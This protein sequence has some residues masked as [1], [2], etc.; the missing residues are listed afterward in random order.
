M[1]VLNPSCSLY[2]YM[3]TNFIPVLTAPFTAAFTARLQKW[4]TAM[5]D[6]KAYDPG[7]SLRSYK[8]I[9]ETESDAHAYRENK[10]IY[11]SYFYNAN[12]FS[13]VSKGIMNRAS[14]MSVYGVVFSFRSLRFFHQNRTC[15]CCASL[16]LWVDR[17]LRPEFLRS[18][19]VTIQE[20][21]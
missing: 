6:Y 4:P 2:Y 18:Q 21:F 20:I 13:S 7:H 19:A 11:P 9:T 15:R 8:R 3:F 16:N 14:I 12:M 17:F 10:S 1:V 5:H